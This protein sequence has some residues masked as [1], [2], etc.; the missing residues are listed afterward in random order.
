MNKFIPAVAVPIIAIIFGVAIVAFPAGDQCDYENDPDC[1]DH[2]KQQHDIVW[3]GPIGVLQYEHRIGENVYFL[4]RDLQPNEKGA[5]GVFTPYGVLYKTIY[6]DG[7]K[8][9]DFNQFFFPDT[10]AELE[11]CTPEELMGVWKVVFTDKSYPTL[12][13]EI[14]DEWLPGAEAAIDVVC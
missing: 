9:P 12:E 3:A 10:T 7:S 1:D 6:Y 14:T 4:I 5:I 13:F 8:K 2:I 11:I